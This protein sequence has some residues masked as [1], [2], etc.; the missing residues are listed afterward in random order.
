MALGNP[1][2]RVALPLGISLQRYT[3]G[4]I[5]RQL[6]Y[7]LWS[8]L[9]I[10]ITMIFL[11]PLFWGL[12]TSLRPPLE[13]FTVNGFG[14][15]WIDFTPTL[16]NWI[17]QLKVPETQAALYNST[18]IATFATLLALAIG[19]PAA[20]GLARFRFVLPPNR[21]ITIFFLAQRI[22]PPVAT[23][24][25][26]YLMMGA[27]GLLDTHLGL[28][29]VNAT[30][31]LPFVVV[32]L[33]Q[34]FLDLPVELE[35]SALVDGADHFR[36]FMRI[37]L[38]LVAPAIAATGLIIFGRAWNEFLFA[39]AIASKGA[40]TIPVH[41]AGTA[42]TRGVYF[43]YLA[44]RQMIAILPPVL[45]ALIAQRYIVRGLTMGAIRG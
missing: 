37:A 6:R 2:G 4:A 24:I 14:I 39:L 22:L 9:A 25:P 5:D 19:T 8:L 15:P 23:V 40:I 12:S 20:Y 41:M 43:W 29:L 45:I 1:S 30:F 13:T 18:I 42:G 7:T 17:D 28:V 21:D 44:V 35:E 32:I 36:A 33:R 11:F 3:P 16:D 10:V 27:L 26:F 34:G 31:I 38:P